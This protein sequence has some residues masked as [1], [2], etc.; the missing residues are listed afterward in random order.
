V[1]GIVVGVDG[2]EGSRA[3][4]AWALEEARLRRVA[5]HA[6]HA[7]ERAI[8][9][10]EVGGF[11]LPSAAVD[12]AAERAALEAA[13]GRVLDEAL[14][15][16]GGGAEPHVVEGGAARALLDAGRGADLIVVGNRGH[17]ELASL[18]MGS[19]S[20]DVAHDAP[21]PVVIVPSPRRPRD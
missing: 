5:V 21:C 16:V 3:A 15:A 17:G 11:G 12:V 14:A 8:S 1:E 20:H 4:L 2:S 6:V 19:V 9:T 18:V 10:V 13:A 7:W